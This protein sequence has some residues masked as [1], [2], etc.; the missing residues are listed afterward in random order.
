MVLAHL[1]FLF[2][3][4]HE[5]FLMVLTQLSCQFGLWWKGLLNGGDGKWTQIQLPNQ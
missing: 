3:Q 2:R 1:A 5:V 4:V